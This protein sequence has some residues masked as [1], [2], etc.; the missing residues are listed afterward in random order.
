[1]TYGARPAELPLLL[2][3]R[4]LPLRS[5][6]A[7][8]RD[9]GPDGLQFVQRRRESARPAERRWYMLVIPVSR[10]RRLCGFLF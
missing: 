1:M 9:G 5:M 10:L 6:S 7:V 4:A 3:D 8:M 2:D